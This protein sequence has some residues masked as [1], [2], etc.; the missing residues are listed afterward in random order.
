MSVSMGACKATSRFA[1]SRLAESRQQSQRTARG[2]LLAFLVLAG[3]CTA[4]G[5]FEPILVGD[6]PAAGGAADSLSA[7]TQDPAPAARPI[8]PAPVLDPGEAAS[9]DNSFPVDTAGES[10][11]SR[12]SG[13]D[14]IDTG[15][16][17]GVSGARD[18]GSSDGGSARD[19][20]TLPRE[21]DASAPPNG[22]NVN[23]PDASSPRP[24]APCPGLVFEGSCYE[25]F[26]EQV[27][28]SHAEERCAAWGGQL[29][30]VESS[31]EDAFM[32]AWPA[33]MGV[34]LL[35]G[36]GLWLGGT[37]ALGDGD[38]RW[39]GDRPLGFTGWA[40]DQPNNGTGVDC[41]EK[42]ND[43]AQGWYDRRCTDGERYVCERPE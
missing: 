42:R 12:G 3:G 35:N 16:D 40:A 30:S 43:F 20:G 32:S 14:A 4:A 5:E 23:E 29:A 28:W 34:P 10:S 39:Q 8:P 24:P 25:F 2:G 33:L 15:R 37:D 9:A 36:A 19:A 26:D 6:A 1:D 11:G 38:F 41:I 7:S 27:S 21:L 18:A 13:T 22:G 17:A 31:E